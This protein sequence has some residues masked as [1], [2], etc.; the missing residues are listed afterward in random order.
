MTSCLQA[1]SCTYM[2]AICILYDFQTLITGGIAIIVAILAGIPVWRQLRDTNLQ[3]R[4]SHRET[5][6][7]LLR[8][9]QRRYGKVSSAMAEPLSR[10]SDLTSDPIGEPTDI[11]AE[12]AHELQMRFHYILD[13]YLVTLVDTE[14]SDI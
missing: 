6:A 10:A 5:L 4:I 12:D 13:W 14:H 9:A 2:T 7:T 1:P 8:D 11:V 3:T